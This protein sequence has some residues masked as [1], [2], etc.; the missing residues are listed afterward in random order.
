MVKL[1]H[2]EHDA[3]W[4]VDTDI[5]PPQRK[6]LSSLASRQSL[7]GGIADA[8]TGVGRVVQRP[9]RRPAHMATFRAFVLGLAVIALVAGP[10]FAKGGGGGG[11]GGAGG[12]GG[13]AGGA[14]GGGNG[15]GPAAS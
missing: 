9:Q 15:P 1:L 13:G 6:L 14:G 2:I 11:G 7:E 10:A 8:A 12:G 3:C 4:R 5:T